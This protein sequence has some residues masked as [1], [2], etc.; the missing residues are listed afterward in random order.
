MNKNAEEPD[1]AKPYGIKLY[2]LNASRWQWRDAYHGLLTLSWP[3]FSLFV[4]AMYLAINV[5]FASGYYL[6]PGC[7]AEMNPHS[8]GDS[9]FF[10]VET[11]ATVGYGHMYP[12]TLYGHFVATVEIITGMFGMAIITG[13]IFIRFSRPVARI[14]FSEGLLLAP[15]DGQLALTL[16]VANLRDQTMME[17]EFRIILM[18]EEPTKE[19]PMFRRFYPLKLQFDR[20]ILFPAIITIRHIIDEQSPLHGWTLA[21]ME[22]SDSRFTTSVVCIDSVVPASVQSHHGYTWKDIR[23]NHR[24]VEVYNAIDDNSLT[25]DYGLIHVT[26]PLT[27]QKPVD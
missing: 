18:R 24:F 6:R 16:R 13:L 19:G 17:A 20:L 4:F 15:F 7:I 22:R 9:F 23:V 12:A 5:L 27:P 21:D 10:S 11:L 8:W 25:V 2:K 1:P 14:V 3:Q 26:E